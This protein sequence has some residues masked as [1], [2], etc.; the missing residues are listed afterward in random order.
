M[1]CK[2]CS[3]PVSNKLFCNRSCAATYNNHARP[4]R[5][6]EGRCAVCGVTLI[7]RLKYCSQ[8]CR[9]TVN[10][11]LSSK[12]TIF[13]RNCAKEKC[14]KPFETRYSHQK[15]CSPSCANSEN[16]RLNRKKKPVEKCPNCGNGMFQGSKKC[17]QCYVNGR[18]GMSIIE[19]LTLGEVQKMATYQASARIRNHARRVY[20]ANSPSSSCEVCPYDKHI[21]VCHVKPI[22][23]F[24]KD[25]LVSTI[26]QRQNLVGLCRNCHW[27]LDNG[28]LN[29]APSGGIEPLTLPS[30]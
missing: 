9:T 30:A 16:Q 13:E 5:K 21:E 19:Q 29:L 20:A 17:I 27:E 18:F 22:C 8:E 4:K 2:Q 10:K 1:Y 6:A 7:T 24:P 28:L 25:T 11:K 26:N 12:L 23:S 14:G 15:F 3:K